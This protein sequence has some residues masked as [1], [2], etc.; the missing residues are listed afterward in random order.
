MSEN[1]QT[2]ELEQFLQQLAGIAETG[3]DVRAYVADTAVPKPGNITA[4]LDGSV[5]GGVIW[6][7]KPDGGRTCQRAQLPD[8]P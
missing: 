3:G 4:V 7:R 5:G 8:A 2:S 6:E 1:E